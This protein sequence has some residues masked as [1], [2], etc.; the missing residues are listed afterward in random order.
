M[1]REIGTRNKEKRKRKK[2]KK[3]ENSKKKTDSSET[4]IDRYENEEHLFWTCYL[5]EEFPFNLKMA[6]IR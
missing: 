3:K 1:W 5:A 2:K 4:K 6:A